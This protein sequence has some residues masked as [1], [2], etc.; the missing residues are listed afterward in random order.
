MHGTK[1][2]L[3]RLFVLYAYYFMGI[4]NNVLIQPLFFLRRVQFGLKSF[5]ITLIANAKTNYGIYAYLLYLIYWHLCYFFGCFTVYI[6]YI[7]R[8]NSHDLIHFHQLFLLFQ[9]TW[10]LA[11]ADEWHS[12]RFALE[13]CSG[14]PI[15]LFGD[16][17][18]PTP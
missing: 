15:S 16:D 8:K 18:V 17:G 3:L 12:F 11:R 14:T 13:S 6:Y 5:V 1:L 7:L 4:V 10:T 9:V 2:T